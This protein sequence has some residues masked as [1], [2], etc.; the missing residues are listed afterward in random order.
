MQ[1]AAGWPHGNSIPSA[2]LE[3]ACPNLSPSGQSQ[4]G[5]QCVA[6]RES[7][8]ANQ[9]HSGNSAESTKDLEKPKAQ[10]FFLVAK[11]TL[12]GGEVRL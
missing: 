3:L 6:S 11:R 1:N 2:C 7:H 9:T 4:V 8:R 5:P 10:I 12:L